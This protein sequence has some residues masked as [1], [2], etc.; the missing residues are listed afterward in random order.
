M[1]FPTWKE[2]ESDPEFQ[3]LEPTKKREYFGKW[4]KTAVDRA[5]QQG[6]Y[7]DEEFASGFTGW[8]NQKAKEYGEE[9]EVGD[10]QQ[11][12]AKYKTPKEVGVFE[13]ISNAARNAFAS[14]QQALAVTGGV[15]PEEAQEIS[16]IEYEK[17]AR[18][19]SPD[20][21]AYQ[22][23]EGWDA[24]NAFINNPVEV[25]TNIVAEGLAGSLPSLG[26]GLATGGVGAAAGSVVPGVGTGAG[27]IAGQVA[28]TFAGSLATEYGS[29]VLE[30]LQNEGMD[31]TNPQSITEFFSNQKLVDAAK[32]KALK[33]GVPIAAFE[34]V[35]AGIGGKVAK[36]LG[37]AFKT[38]TRDAAAEMV[39]Q[40]ALGVGGEIAGTTAAGDEFDGKELFAELAGSIGPD[41][42]QIAIGKA[43]Q[44][45]SDRRKQRQVKQAAETAEKLENSD[46]P[47]TADALKTTVAKN[48]V[49]QEKQT[50]D[51]LDEDLAGEVEKV[52]GMQP[53][54]EEEAFVMP[55]KEE[56][57]A[58]YAKLTPESLAETE[59]SF[60][61]QLQDED[62]DTR[63][64]AQTAL[65]ALAEFKAE[66]TPI[67]PAAEAPLEQR[68]LATETG[69]QMYQAEAIKQALANRQPVGAD[70]IE[71]FARDPRTWG[72]AIPQD[73][74]K[75]G[76]VYVP[77]PAVE[78]PAEVAPAQAAE[79]APPVEAAPP[80]VVDPTAVAPALPVEQTPAEPVPAVDPETITTTDVQPEAPIT[81]PPSATEPP[82]QNVVG[83]TTARG[84]TYEITPEG[85]T[86]RMK[87]SE[88]RGQGEIHPPSS[89]LFV[90]EEDSRNILG[91][92]QSTFGKAAVRL[93]YIEGNAF[94]PITDTR[95]IPAGAQPAVVSVER[96]NNKVLG[97][98]RAEIQPKVGLSPVEKEYMPD[99]NA[100]LHIG[101]PIVS[102]RQAEATPPTAPTAEAET[103]ASLSRV[104]DNT[105]TD[106]EVVRLA[107]QGLVNI[108]DGQNVITPR[109]EE[110]MQRAGAPLPRLTPEERA[111]EVAAAPAAI[112]EQ[113]PPVAESPI[114]TPAP[115]PGVEPIESAIEVARK[116]NFAA[117]ATRQE[118][119]E[120]GR[121]IAS[122]DPNLPPLPPPQFDVLESISNLQARRPYNPDALTEDAINEARD[123]G[124]ITGKQVG[125]LKLTE[126]GR[127]QLKEW[128]DQAR[129]RDFAESS[130]RDEIADIAVSQWDAAND[131]ESAAAI[132]ARTTRP[133]TPVT[134][135]PVTEAVT[136]AP[137]ATTPAAPKVAPDWEKMSV[138][139]K[140]GAINLNERVI[141]HP[142]FNKL[143]KSIDATWAKTQGKGEVYQQD[144]DLQYSYLDATILDKNPDAKKTAEKIA[145]DLGVKIVKAPAT[146]LFG[147]F[148]LEIPKPATA[149]TPTIPTP[150]ALAEAAPVGIAV[151]NRV[152]TKTTP[153]SFVVEE[154]LPQSA[155]EA[156]LG[157]QYYSIRNERTGEVQT[158][159]AG[160]IRA[161]KGKGGRQMA[162]APAVTAELWA[163]PP[164]EIS[165]AATSINQRQMPA[166]FKRVKWQSGTRNADIGG[167]RFDNAT[168]YLADIGVENVIY[169][170]YNRTQESNQAAVSKISGGQSD[171]ATVNNVLNVIAEPES[172]NLVIRQAADAIKPNGKAYFLIYEGNKKGVGSPTASGWQENRKA[173]TYIAEI[174][175]HFGS[176]TRKGNLITAENP[177]KPTEVLR[178]AEGIRVEED[179]EVV[180]EADRY[181]FDE[182]GIRAIEFFNGV[183]PD[184]LVIVN[185]SVDP[186]YRFKASYDPNTGDITLN[187]AF[188]RKGESIEDILSH[189]LGHYIFS[190]PKFQAAFQRFWNEMSD[191]E[192]ANADKIINQFYSKQSGAVQI[193]EKKVRA[194]MALVEEARLL[195]RWKQILNAIKQWLND[196][197]GTNFNV[198]DRGALSVLAVAHKRFRKGEVIVR[199]M[200]EGVFRMAAEP[201]PAPEAKAAPAERPL[202][203]TKMQNIINISTGVKRPRTKLT[204][205]EMAALKDQIRIGARKRREDKQTQKEFAK[206]VTE[207]LRGMAI[208][209][210]VSAPQLRA[211]TSKAMQTQFDNE[212]SI[213]SFINYANKVIENANYNR[214]ISDAKAAIKSAKRL[215]KQKGLAGNIKANLEKLAN[216][217][218]RQIEPEEMVEVDGEMPVSV[219]E[220][221]AVLKEYMKAAGPVTA[222]GYILVPDAEI[223]DFLS[224]I[225]EQV[226]VNRKAN[227]NLGLDGELAEIADKT[228]EEI[229]AE[230]ARNEER[231]KRIEEKV[232]KLAEEAQIGLVKYENPEITSEE[233]LVLDDMKRIT[234]SDISIGERKEFVKVANNILVNNKFLGAQKFAS[235]AR[236]QIGAAEA[237]KDS[238]T[239]K[240]NSATLKFYN[241]FGEDF[242]KLINLGTQSFADTFR[243]LT[244]TKELPRLLYQ[245]GFG[246]IE[247]GQAN[248]NRA[249]RE[250]T[251]GVQNRFRQ[252]E[253]ET[254]QKIAD[255]QGVYSMGVAGNLI[256]IHPDETEAEGIQRM[257]GL[258]KSD[259]EK[260]KKSPK[261]DDRKAA[262]YIQKALDEV[263]SDTVEGVLEN[264][265][266]LH[267]AN[268]KA[269]TFLMN[270]VLPEYKPMLK[271][272]DELFNNQTENYENP[273][274]LPI[275]Y[276]S[277]GAE[278]KKPGELRGRATD[279]VT[280]PKQAPNSIKRIKNTVL[281]EGKQ[282]D[283][284]LTRNVL[285]SLSTQLEA[286]YTNPGWQQ[287]YAFLKSPEAVDALGGVENY[288]FVTRRI[289]NLSD[290][291][292]RRIYQMDPFNQAADFVANMVRKIGTSIALGGVGQA[293]KQMPDQV[294]TTIANVNDLS[295]TTPAFTEIKAALPA[296]R[297][298]SIG[299]RGE[300][301]GGSKWVNQLEGNFTKLQQ[302]MQDGLWPK[303]MEAFE[304]INN[305]WLIPLKV[306]DTI[307]ASHGWISYYKKYLK[308]NNIPFTNWDNEAE[309]IAGGERGRVE[310]GLYADQMIDLYQGSSDPT[311]MATFAQRGDS[312]GGN[313]LK[314]MI[315]PFSSFVIQQ[316][317]RI[318]SDLRDVSYGDADEKK[319]AA[320]G[321][322]GTLLGIVI[323]HGVRRYALPLLTGGVAAGAYG[324]LGVDM[325]EPDEEEKA[326][327]EKRVF[328]QFLGEVAANIFVGGYSA[329]AE[330]RLIDAVNAASYFYEI[331]TNSDNVLDDEGEIMS[332]E[333]YRKERAPMYR[334][335][336]PGADS[337]LGMI[338][339]LPSQTRETFDRLKDLSD[340]EIMDSLT[341]EEQRVLIL[342]ALSE[343]LYTMRLNDAD[344]ARMIKRMAKDV[345]DQAEARQKAERK[346][347][348]LY[349]L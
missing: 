338:D 337:T 198:T 329:Y 148:R 97:V 285:D 189:E 200:N 230:L 222:E 316:R 80:A 302:F 341:E 55:P 310:A 43:Q 259:I 19:V 202:R 343:T 10:F 334:Y 83:F 313:L 56:F 258:I 169:D 287:V 309:L 46:A 239:V 64:F 104:A 160:D 248:T 318:L 271:E 152:K 108:Q 17:N 255:T 191:V 86:I 172:R 254:G 128:S 62:A 216:I 213:K 18:Q 111:A 288:D 176:V 233:K 100:Y 44:I 260:K 79:V 210:K 20:Y 273:Y 147:G 69:A 203:R 292:E 303:A 326:E 304:N 49:E 281:P 27:F 320:K 110:V 155:R 174:R 54:R 124:F 187:R 150:T 294:A 141:N 209:G 344:V 242:G 306:S 7:R 225:G 143:K 126:S 95:S 223:T 307:A 117:A 340:D 9:E 224:K 72:I 257:R 121:N 12:S 333:K 58:S 131:P 74:I 227:E 21:K 314:T 177:I 167:G 13:G 219:A 127:N 24:V 190:D 92:Q 196:K 185:D 65:E 135:P 151:G 319:V 184:G 328:R 38:K 197:F 276:R 246:E 90:S 53:I 59:A 275:R 243:N 75:Q 42:A 193:E 290:S 286:A 237:A 161:I 256:Q 180:P 284:N 199:E 118:A 249:R 173:E 114:V 113:A 331:Q 270:E 16:K 301:A 68:P 29:K 31:L 308:D 250:I 229:D 137:A 267:P 115:T 336:G 162:A 261:S 105:A 130:L 347:Q 195:P 103:S 206:D 125:K 88:G 295:I 296:M 120:I 279:S 186:E 163:T 299:E 34:A 335:T 201:T 168:D 99:G 215:A 182:A 138:F 228:P 136:P 37:T 25:T 35:S 109:G 134:T 238:K 293:A 345:K 188:I 159:E 220:F 332:W 269:M 119:G 179:A 76:N 324:L 3:S 77:P 15:T 51:K 94:N 236:G 140:A 321:L 41:G 102:V 226:E 204:V 300:I 11:L 66:Q 4:S 297:Q 348:R 240:R 8:Y 101:N 283:Y 221:T 181:T 36:I 52:S 28:G 192:K 251:D 5:M 57:K 266:R 67:P 96:E 91:D 61:E 272:H 144:N 81:P 89:V 14:S 40:A 122:Q 265:K 170:P 22:E 2:V 123:S 278:P 39:T 194:F 289:N 291:R 116:T 133:P 70:A 98:Y 315:M 244:G 323:F 322:A 132:A 48:I 139:D 106:E 156:E 253:K 78:A 149:T 73:Y 245:M 232:N 212:A 282:L 63:A 214:D 325:E 6:L 247:R 107:R 85:K 317:S 175:K 231:R 311:K 211:I 252:I 165:S 45:L 50:A 264:L 171:T 349:G 47:L 153:Q 71:F 218:P 208:R 166:T 93:G 263:D 346:L 154:V 33:K 305:F 145:S 32:E 129:D 157:E 262:I 312:G 241:V 142:L 82:P 87:R 178:Q 158:V 280:A 339:I 268:H 207:Y 112:V 298:F 205:D 183:A 60:Q 146:S 26:A 30:E 164:Q 234:L 327:K 235:I 84:S 342:A 277:I 1:R 330:T 274:Y 217:D 23:A